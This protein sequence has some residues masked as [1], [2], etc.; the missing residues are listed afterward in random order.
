MRKR[1]IVVVGPTASG[2]TA[3]SITL[4]ERL[5]AP[6]L[7]ILSADSR[8][9]YRGMAIGTAQPSPEER[10]RALHYLVDNHEVTEIY[11]AGD[12]ERE[13]LETLDELFK[14]HDCVV[15]VGG[16]GLYIDALCHGL[17]ALPEADPALRA[18][19]EKRWTF[20]RVGLLAELRRLDPD[21]FAQVD[22]AN[23]RRVVRALEVC[24]KSGAPYSTLRRKNAPKRAFDILKIGIE[25]P[26]A[27]LYERIDR[28]VERMM[29]AGLEAEA[30][31]LYPQ[32]ALSALQTVGYREMFDHFDE[33]ITREQAVELI[34][35]NTRRYA[36]RQMTWFSKDASIR[37]F[38]PDE[39]EKIV[40]FCTHARMV[41]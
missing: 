25:M 33:K 22:R 18:E 15:A 23:P 6:S 12:Y 2:K 11:T 32:R 30:R 3:L 38:A 28:R 19:L 31:A 37:W 34:Q 4:A 26:R 40:Y 21:H 7:P 13:A 35:R 29:E 14:I 17:D 39:I 8:Q 27:Q 36:K 10:A 41:E 24:L 9:V 1:L 20:D 5:G 16:S